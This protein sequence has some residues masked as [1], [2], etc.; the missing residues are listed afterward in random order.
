MPAFNQRDQQLEAQVNVAGDVR[1]DITIAP[2]PPRWS[3]Q[4]RQERENRRRLLVRVRGEVESWLRGSLEGAAL[5]VL[6][7]DDRPAAVPDLWGMLVQEQ[8]R[9]VVEPVPSGEITGVFDRLDEELL[10]LGAPGSGKTTL[11]LELARTLIGRAEVDEALPVPVV[12]PLASWAA[13]RLPLTDW[14]AGEFALRYSIPRKLA[15]AWVDEDYVL[16]L[17]DGLDEVAAE[18][19]AACVA[20]INAFREGRERA[21]SSLV[22]CCRTAEY[23]A[24]PQLRLRGAVHI[25]P[26][27]GGQVD[28]YL[29]AGGEQLVGLRTA[30][31]DDA[32]LQEL[33]ATPL[34]LHLMILTYVAAPAGALPAA[35]TA[36]ER[37]TQLLD[38][39]IARM[40]TRRGVDRRYTPAQTIRWLAW[41]ACGLMRQGRTDFYLDRLQPDWLPTRAT[42]RWYALIDRPGWALL[43][44]LIVALIFGL[45][46]GLV[47]HPSGPVVGP[48]GTPALVAEQITGIL[49]APGRLLGGYTSV[50]LAALLFGLVF[51]FFGGKFSISPEE[52]RGFRQLGRELTTAGRGLLLG[53]ATGLVFGLIVAMAVSLR[54]RPELATWLPR[55]PVVELAGAL[56]FGLAGALAYALASRL[57]IG[58]AVGLAYALAGGLAYALTVGLANALT[59]PPLSENLFNANLGLALMYSL[60]DGVILGLFFSLPA[61]IVSMLTGG[62]GTGP[63]WISP[64]ES[65]KWSPSKS[66]R[67]TSIGLLFGLAVTLAFGLV[68][69]LGS[70]IIWGLS[71]ERGALVDGLRAGLGIGLPY[72]LIY[73]LVAGLAGGL[74]VGQV[75]NRVSPNQGIRRSVRRAVFLGPLF[76]LVFG[77]VFGLSPGLSFGLAPGLALGLVPGL[78]LTLAFGGYACLSHLTLRLVLWRC[79][80]MP[81]RYV[82]FLDYATE[83]IFLRRVGG[84]YLFVHR[85]V[86][87][88]FAA[89]ETDKPTSRRSAVALSP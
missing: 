13:E 62:P 32:E 19:R 71:I 10:I 14:L 4:E 9:E 49:S 75:E 35:G 42:R 47:H 50:G 21:L 72:G 60:D 67:A 44:G 28:A 73:G 5:L 64:V 83:R 81:L 30:L 48:P 74:T 3:R 29:A 27:D 26:L 18:H 34:V 2:A 65:V 37:R 46:G 39:Y 52:Q 12:V 57:V 63:R 87:E 41:L 82:D 24:L 22:V 54:R 38:A 51:G 88:H 69:G 33:A 70:A 17:L 68:G 78:A 36:E 84:G 20:S 16:P 45:F 56:A 43:L 77:L 31:R 55:A 25:H 80:V 89:M 76:M 1:G 86:Q 59:G 61:G 79:G 8:G 58:L 7:L 15:R 53:L 66:A 40:F 11:L 23:E 85:L 6:G